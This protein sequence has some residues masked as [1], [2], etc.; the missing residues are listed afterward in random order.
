MIFFTFDTPEEC[1]KFTFLYKT[2]SKIIYLTIRK[3]TDHSETIEDLAQDIF[4]KIADHLD[5]VDLDDPQRTRNFIITIAR[6]HCKNYLRKQSTTPEYL[7]ENIPE[8]HL[9]SD[10]FD[11]SDLM[12][13]IEL[14]E[15]LIAEIG[16]LSDIYQ[17]VLELK[18]ISQFR[19]DE[20]ADFLGIKKKTV[21]VQLYRAKQ[22]LKERLV[23]WYENS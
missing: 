1:D 15:Q 9:H 12:Q 18:Y 7:F 14:R 19:N 16:K 21:E 22:L 23:N 4:I 8:P 5:K 6:N 2:Y 20:I 11:L 13:K 3:F 10:V 17:M